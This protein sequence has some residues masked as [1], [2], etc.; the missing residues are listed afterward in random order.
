MMEPT[1]N[2]NKA[3]AMLVERESHRSITS[4]SMSGEGTKLEALMTGKTMHYKSL[5]GEGI[6]LVAHLA[7][8][9]MNNRPN[10]S[11]ND[12]HYQ[13]GKKTWDQKCHYCKMQGHVID[14]CY[15]LHGYP[16]DWKPKNRCNSNTAYHVQDEN[17]SL[18][19]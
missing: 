7:N 2:I 11:A 8:R 16:L 15:K 12:Q 14:E 6:E 5:I 3:Y 19:P 4:F 10:R 13:K 1:P 17:A 18:Q 9:G